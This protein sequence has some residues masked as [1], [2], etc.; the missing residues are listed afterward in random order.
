MTLIVKR[1]I[2]RDDFID[3]P[4]KVAAD[5]MAQDPSV[6]EA[7]FDAGAQQAQ[8]PQPP[9]QKAQAPRMSFEQLAPYA[10]RAVT[11]R[12]R[13]VAP[14]PNMD[15]DMETERN[16]EQAKQLKSMANNVKSKQK[17]Q[18]AQQA[19]NTAQAPVQAPTLPQQ[20]APGLASEQE[21]G[22]PKMAS[23]NFTCNTMERTPAG[24]FPKGRRSGKTASDR[25]RELMGGEHGRPFQARKQRTLNQSHQAVSPSR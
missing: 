11:M 8:Q 5:I 4:A 19:L 21:V 25:L 23:D 2:W 9:A 14:D 3:V 22:A 24:Q 12:P 1:G 10:Q 20:Q 15:I 18:Q 16:N 13:G 6:V 17:L 7:G